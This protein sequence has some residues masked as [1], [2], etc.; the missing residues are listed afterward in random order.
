MRPSLHTKEQHI[1]HSL[2]ETSHGDHANCICVQAKAALEAGQC[3]VIGLQ[4]TGEAAADALGLKPGPAPF[5]S[6]TRELLLR[7]VEIHFPVQPP[8]SAEGERGCRRQHGSAAS[9]N[10]H[11]SEVTIIAALPVIH[12]A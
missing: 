5:V 10:L 12:D 9:P 8:V 1:L 7:F 2:A 4:S 11:V 6:T 3:V